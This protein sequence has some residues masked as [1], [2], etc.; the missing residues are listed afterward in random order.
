MRGQTMA[1]IDCMSKSIDYQSEQALRGLSNCRRQH[2]RV[3]CAQ[4]MHFQTPQMH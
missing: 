1:I 2:L 3:Q 4:A